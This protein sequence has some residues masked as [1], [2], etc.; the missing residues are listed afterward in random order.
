MI[1]L[2]LWLFFIYGSAKFKIKLISILS[3][4]FF[5]YCFLCDSRVDRML[6]MRRVIPRQ[7]KITLNDF[8]TWKV[9]WSFRKCISSP[10]ALS[11]V[12]TRLALP[13]L[14][15]CAAC[16]FS[17]PG[18]VIKKESLGGTVARFEESPYSDP[19]FMIHLSKSTFR[20]RCQC[21]DRSGFKV[22]HLIYLQLKNRMSSW[23][24]RFYRVKKIRMKECP[25]Y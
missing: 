2:S 22:T 1:I 23:H 19:N 5:V 18:E 12:Q 25:E 9:E 11:F 4:L 20:S 7:R 24:A 6:I 16:T 8:A 10:T 21:V 13:V 3:V 14:R 15:T 17:Q